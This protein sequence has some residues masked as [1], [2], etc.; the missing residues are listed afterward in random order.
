MKSVLFIGIN[1]KYRNFKHGLQW[2]HLHRYDVLGLFEYWN[3]L[4]NQSCLSNRPDFSHCLS[5]GYTSTQHGKNFFTG[6]CEQTL[7]PSSFIPAMLLG[8]TVLYHFTSLSVTLIVGTDLNVSEKEHLLALLS[9][10]TD[11][12][13][14]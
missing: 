4:Y 7:Q 5:F 6:H 14:V 11:Q 12:D 8:T 9:C 13:D 1:D 10:T 2:K 3:S